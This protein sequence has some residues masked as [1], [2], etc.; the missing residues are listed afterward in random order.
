MKEEFVPYSLAIEL[1]ELGFNEHCFAKY[2]DDEK[3]YFP[4]LPFS[5]DLNSQALN[6]GLYTICDAPLYQQAFGFFREKYS[7]FHKIIDGSEMF[8]F[9]ISKNPITIWGYN[10]KTYEEAETACLKK[11]IE[12]VKQ[13]LLHNEKTIYIIRGE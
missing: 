1:K 6:S 8:S 2:Y 10:F 3:L 12:T 4:D 7:L 11:I 13:K 5:S 9:E